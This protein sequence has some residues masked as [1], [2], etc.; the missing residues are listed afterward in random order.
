MH[1]IKNKFNSLISSYFMILF[2]QLRLFTSIGMVETVY[3]H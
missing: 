2:V 1:F 3:D